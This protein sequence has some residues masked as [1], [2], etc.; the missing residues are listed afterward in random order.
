MTAAALSV[1]EYAALN[2]ASARSVRRWLKADLLPGAVQDRVGRWS[3]PSTV[4]PPVLRPDRAPRVV[5]GEVVTDG[6]GYGTI[7]IPLGQAV[8]RRPDHNGAAVVVTPEAP[9]VT[10]PAALFMTLAEV[11]ALTPPGP[12]HVSERSLAAL[13]RSGKLTGFRSGRSGAWLI[14]TGEVARLAGYRT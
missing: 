1:E 11:A 14:P 3:I 4:P 9:R 2:D 13:C 5:T 12:S 10:L 8:A 6:D 7:P